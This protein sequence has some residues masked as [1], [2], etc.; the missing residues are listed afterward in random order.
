MEKFELYDVSG[1][2]DRAAVFHN[3][4]VRRNDRLKA[5]AAAGHQVAQASIN[6]EEIQSEEQ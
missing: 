4:L 6:V 1:R 3:T 5:A 2:I